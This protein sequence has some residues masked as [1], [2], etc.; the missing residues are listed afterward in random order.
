MGIS[1]SSALATVA[2]VD[3]AVSN[4][5][6]APVQAQVTNEPTDTVQLTSAQQVYNLYNEGQ[7]VPQIAFSLN[8]P[9]PVVNGYLGISGS[10][11]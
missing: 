1:I 10:S 8:L 5:N 9:V 2:V 11:S 3:N 6:P 7:S 4:S